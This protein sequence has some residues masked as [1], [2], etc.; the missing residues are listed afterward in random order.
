M[1]DN[2]TVR[3]ERPGHVLVRTVAEEALLLNTSTETYF[4]LDAVGRTAFEALA[5]GCTISEAVSV[6]CESF[7]EADPAV[8]Q[9]DVEE[10]V[11]AFLSAGLLSHRR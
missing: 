5:E 2:E 11:G 1:P 9:Y 3:F 7:D 6:L 8:V 4:S 10:L